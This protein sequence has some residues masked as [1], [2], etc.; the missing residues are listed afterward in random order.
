MRFGAL[1]Q[2]ILRTANPFLR[3]FVVPAAK[4]VGGDLIEK[5][6]PEIENVLTGKKKFKSAAADFGKKTQRKKL[7]A[8]KLDCVALFEDRLQKSVDVV[9]QER[10]RLQV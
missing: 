4:R 10:I 6:A 3:R 2:T 7:R 5:T 8:G 1:A 9:E